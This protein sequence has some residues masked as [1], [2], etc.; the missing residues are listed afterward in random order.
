MRAFSVLLYGKAIGTL[1]D[2]DGRYGLTFSEEYRE[3][4]DPPIL[5]LAF[6]SSRGRPRPPK[7]TAARMLPFFANLLPEPYSSLRRFLARE[8]A[9]AERDDMSLLRYLGSDLPG[10]ITLEAA[11]WNAQNRRD[12]IAVPGGMRFS[13]AGVQMKFSVKQTENGFAVPAAG[14]SGTH[15]LKLP[16]RGK[17]ELAENECSMMRFA[18]RCGIEAP[19]T[20]LV[21][22]Q[23]V[24]GLPGPFAAFE[25]NAYVIERFDRAPE[26]RRHAEDFAQILGVHP[27]DKYERTTFDNLLTLCANVLGEDGLA[28][29]VRRLVFSIAIANADMHLKNWSLLYA[30][31]DRPVLSPAYD[32]VCTAA[33]AGYDDFLALPLAGARHWNAI[34][35]QTFMTAARNA[36]VSPHIVKRNVAAMVERIREE[37]K[38]QHEKAPE[39]VARIVGR[40]LA[41]PL[42]KGE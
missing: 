36:R 23:N 32:Y 6:W 9:V 10:A 29:F 16:E 12:E 42:F 41:A 38:A 34:R 11:Q 19:K 5:S 1:F 25:G 3:S 30:A 18:A 8:A 4:A 26:G 20:L 27:E 2:A 17:P 14:E 28:E 22:A 13:L 35:M 24:Q 33:Y 37:W 15:I 7:Q 31:P 21:T 39:P 40:Q